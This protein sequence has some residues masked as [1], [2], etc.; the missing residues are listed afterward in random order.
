MGYRNIKKNITQNV[1]QQLNQNE[2]LDF[3]KLISVVITASPLQNMN[4][5]MREAAGCNYIL[6]AHIF[7]VNLE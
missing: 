7:I 2:N 6:L 5:L 1:V 4:L 3:R